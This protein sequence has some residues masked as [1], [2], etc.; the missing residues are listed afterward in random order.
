MPRRAKGP[1]LY[2]YQRRGREA[3]WVI[4]GLGAEVSTGCSEGDREGAERELARCIS[5]KYEPPKVNGQLDKVAIA[6]VIQVYLKEHAPKTV[7]HD[8]ILFLSGAVLDFWG[9]KYL[10]D[11]RASSCDA[12]VKWR[13]AQT[14]RTRGGGPVSVRTARHELNLLRTAIG[15]YHGSY[16]PL[17]AVPVVT[18]PEAPPPRLDYWLTRKEVADRIRVARKNKRWRHVV[19][20]LLIGCYTGTRPGT[21]VKLRW[22]PS[23]DGTG[24][25]FDLEAETLHRRGPKDTISKKVASRCRIHKRLL[26][27]LRRWKAQDEREGVSHVVHYLGKPLKKFRRSWAAVAR[28]AR[29]EHNDGP[30]IM[31][32]TAATWQMQAGTMLAEAAGYL[33]MSPETLWNVYGHHHPD[34]QEK[35]ARASGK[36]RPQ[37][38]H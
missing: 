36:R 3:V 24:G 15:Y 11:I 21:T 6:D 33:G 1:R 29:H 7:R 2:L 19:R 28:A 17:T 8:N 16:G 27:W 22:V 23:I 9:E 30:H 20:M 31:R 4:R 18:L 25:W 10:S 12:Y 32:H 38:R 34:F 26:P 14:R 37:L 13:T 35:A 5:E